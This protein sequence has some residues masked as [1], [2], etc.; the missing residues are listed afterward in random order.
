MTQLDEVTGAYEQ[1]RED[2]IRGVLA[3]VKQEIS[4]HEADGAD[5]SRNMTERAMSR[6]YAEIVG[7]LKDKLEKVYS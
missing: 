7:N 1:G 6:V 5:M 4:K 3:I 2:A